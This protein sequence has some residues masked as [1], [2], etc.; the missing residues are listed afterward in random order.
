LAIRPTPCRPAVAPH[1]RTVEERF[2]LRLQAM[3]A[4][5]SGPVGTR[6]NGAYLDAA[7]HPGEV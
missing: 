2:R 5:L 4:A 1:A 6:V 7:D 3:Q